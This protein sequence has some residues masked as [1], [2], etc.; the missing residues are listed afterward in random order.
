MGSVA[1]TVALSANAANSIA[2][3]IFI[4]FG[5]SATYRASDPGDTTM[6]HLTDAQVQAAVNW[7]VGG[8]VGPSPLLP[9]VRG[10]DTAAVTAFPDFQT[11]FLGF[12]SDQH[13]DAIT[14]D[15]GEAWVVESIVTAD[16]A[17]SS[18]PLPAALS[19]FASGGALLA[20]LGWRRKRRALA[21]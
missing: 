15:S 14:L 17:I 6:L 21:A 18:T 20:F 2:S 12:I 9:L 10:V 16:A 8:E 19:L 11:L 3:Q 4:V 1:K 13:F 5:P 7:E